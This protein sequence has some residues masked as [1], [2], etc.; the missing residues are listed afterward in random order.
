MLHAECARALYSASA[1]QYGKPR[2]GGVLEISD[3][4]RGARRLRIAI[5]HNDD[6]L[7]SRPHELLARAD[8]EHVAHA[9]AAALEGHDVALL[10]VEADLSRLRRRL[11]EFRPDCAFNL[12]ESLLN[13]GRLE[14]AV[15]LVLELMDMPFTGSTADALG[16]AV[17]KHELNQLLR[18]RGVPA[19]AGQLFTSADA[20]CELPFP[21]MVKPAREDGSIGISAR[22]LVRSEGELRGAVEEVLTVLR[23]PCLV[24][25]Y[26]DGREFAVSLLGGPEPDVLPLSEIDFSL[27]PPGAPRLV[28]Y[29]AKWD[30]ESAECKGTVPRTDPDLPDALRSRIRDAARA[31]FRIAGLRDYGRVDLRVSADGVPWV[32]DVN[33]NCD[34]SPDAGFAR[35]ARAAGIEFPQLV[36]RLVAM[37]LQRAAPAARQTA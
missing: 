31:A 4:R 12:C 35:A 3:L 9:V 19:P 27:L 21:L 15:P 11:E 29:R 16:R 32:I 6:F 20:R 28:C 17:E 24:E 8:V 14:S 23:Q 5:L 30:L 22:S 34:L 26:V 37:A 7:E 25:Q 36:R 2:I 10:P 13:D 18:A 1:L 33:P